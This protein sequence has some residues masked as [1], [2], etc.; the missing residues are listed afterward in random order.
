MRKVMLGAIFAVLAALAGCE[1]DDGAIGPAGP[2]GATGAAGPQG[3]AGVPSAVTRDDVVTTNANIAY[4]SYSDSWLLAIELKAAVD[5]LVA[6][7][8]QAN[9][10]AAKEAW[11]AANEPYGQTE[12]YRFRVGPIDAL[13][14]DGS[15]GQE[16]DGPEGAINAWPLGE[17]LI[18]YVAAA[19]DGDAGPEI[20]NSTDTITGNIIAD[21]TFD[22]TED[23]L[24]DNNELGGDERNL[25]TGFHA[26]EFLLWGQDLNADLSG[27]GT[28]DMTGGQRPVSDYQTGGACTSGLGNGQADQICERRGDYLVLVTQLLID[29]LQTLVDAWNP[30]GTGNHYQ[31]FVAGG[32]VSLAKILEGMGRLGF[33]ELAG[34]RMNIALLT[35]S[36]EDE[37]S[38]FSDNTHRDIVTNAMGIENAYFG[39]YTRIDGSVV[40]GAGID[41]LLLAEGFTGTANAFRAALERTMIRISTIDD[42]AKAGM[43]FDTQIQLGINEPNIAGSIQ[44]LSAQTDVLETVI[45]DLGVTVGDLR[46]DTEEDI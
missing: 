38:C 45:S 30:N 11:L 34:E 15:L 18:D 35:N 26:I 1:G 4:A 2:A 10:D 46:Q 43:P 27:T 41:D 29:D 20:P 19:V 42:M 37:H 32:D 33:G 40:D 39:S 8:T 14:P 9:F 5:A 7:P 25:T 3:P 22:I 36:Q 23:A 24:R 12:V 21:L 31:N 6:D 16:G 17:A 28:R 13:L 44:A